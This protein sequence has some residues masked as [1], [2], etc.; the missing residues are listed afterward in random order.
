[1]A[2]FFFFF[3]FFF[4]DMRIICFHSY[5]YQMYAK[6]LNLVQGC[7]STLDENDLPAIKFMKVGN[8]VLP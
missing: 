4:P 5:A 3:S 6:Y 2:F 7:A 1:M 8:N